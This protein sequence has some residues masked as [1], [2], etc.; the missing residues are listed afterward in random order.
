MCTLQHSLATPLR[1][2]VLDNYLKAFLSIY[3]VTF[4]YIQCSLKV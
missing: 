4:Q 2:L 3:V 1:K